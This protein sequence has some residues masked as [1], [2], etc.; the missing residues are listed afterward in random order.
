MLQLRKP[1]LLSCF[2]RSNICFFCSSEIYA[3]LQVPSSGDTHWKTGK[4][5]DF[6]ELE[7]KVWAGTR[8]SDKC[9]HLEMDNPSRVCV[10]YSNTMS[11]AERSHERK[12]TPHT[13]TSNVGTTNKITAEFFFV[14]M[15]VQQCQFCGDSVQQ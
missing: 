12:P 11:Q 14:G 5:E 1:V 15:R 4:G 3:S 13:K 7:E 2:F 8:T 10:S 6:S 9:V